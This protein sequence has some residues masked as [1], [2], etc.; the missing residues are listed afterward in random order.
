MKGMTRIL[1]FAFLLIL[2]FGFIKEKT[3]SAPSAF[4]V[5]PGTIWFKDSLYFD[6]CEVTNLDYLEFLYWIGRHHPERYRSLLPD[7]L[8]WWREGLENG[9]N[10]VNFYFRHPAYRNFPVVGLSHQQAVQYCEWRTERVNEYYYI[11]DHHI[12]GNWKADSIYPYPEIVQYR[13]PTREEWIFAA[14]CYGPNSRNQKGDARWH[15][16][17]GRLSVNTRERILMQQNFG[18]DEFEWLAAEYNNVKKS[19]KPVAMNQNGLYHMV[20]N[21]SEYISDSSIVAGLSF[22]TLLDGQRYDFKTKEYN[23]PI[24]DTIGVPFYNNTGTSCTVGFRCICEV[25]KATDKKSK[26]SESK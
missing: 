15:D 6:Q 25:K 18:N 23:K 14:A 11:R 8:C 12:A 21:V 22:S 24:M 2:S 20:G 1:V 10:N 7:T 5:P 3:Q 9:I 19:K 26:H 17:N 16:K 4:E 13:L